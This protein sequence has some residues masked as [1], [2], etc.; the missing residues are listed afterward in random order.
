MGFGQRVNE[1]LLARNMTPAQL[2][3]QLGWNTGALSQYLNNPD[4]DPRL[5]TAVKVARALGV[6]LE[7]LAGIEEPSARPSYADPG[8]AEL[9][10]CWESCNRESRAALLVVARNSAGE[11][12]SEAGKTRGTE[13]KPDGAIRR[14]G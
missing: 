3:K 2:S 8:Q 6:S 12:K 4:R 11:S 13:G 1:V 9:N 14:A 5:S 10:A 7:Y